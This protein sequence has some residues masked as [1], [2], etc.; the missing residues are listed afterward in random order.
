MAG[1]EEQVFVVIQEQEITILP[2]SVVMVVP[3]VAADF[4]RVLVSQLIVA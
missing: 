2:D 4:T 3:A 1:E